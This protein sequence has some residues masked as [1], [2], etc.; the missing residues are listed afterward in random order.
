MNARFELHLDQAAFDRWLDGQQGKYEWKEGRVVQMANVTRAHAR[1]EKNLI[2]ALSGRLN[3]EKWEVLST[4]FGVEKPTF[5]RFPA[6]PAEVSGRD[7]SIQLPALGIELPLAD[8][9]RGIGA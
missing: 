9:F 4:E 2:L 8:I 7:Q 6:T 1:I 5:T 3:L